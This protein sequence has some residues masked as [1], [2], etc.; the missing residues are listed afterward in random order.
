M[1][2]PENP[3]ET[4]PDPQ[5]T[6]LKIL[7]WTTS[8][9]KSHHI[10]S[11]RLTAEI[12]LA[13]I[14]CA[15]RIDLYLKFDQPLTKDELGI[16]KTFIKRRVNR[17]PVS[18]ITGGREFWGL[19]FK[20]T[21]DV[22]IPRPETEFL[23]EESLKLIPTGISSGRFRVID[24][25]TG[26]GAVIVSLA[27]HRPGHVYFASDI[28]PGA[29]KIAFQ[30]AASNNVS[31]EIRFFAGELFHPLNAD[32]Q[33]F[34][35]IVSNPPYIPNSQINGLAPEV[36]RY[37][38]RLALDGG[39]EGLEILA[40]II[41]DTPEYLKEKGVL[42]LEIGFDQMEHITHIVREDGRYSGLKF[43][44][45]YSGHNRVAIMHRG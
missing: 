23:V 34:D 3:P 27:V 20:V 16:F 10:D 12:L 33:K 9:F 26:S 6:I 28:S 36:S 7:Q 5:W 11:P 35:L 45:D 22:L 14:L 4:Q 44:Q 43:I 31:A 8:Y 1:Q 40:R 17:E 32:D 30:N 13:H 21:P 37:E 42:M 41:R 15:D 25:G 2:S 24:V 38:P 19:D 29:L 39:A 18:Y